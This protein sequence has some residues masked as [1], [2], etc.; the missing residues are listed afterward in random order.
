VNG[1]I[2]T[3]QPR[4]LYPILGTGSFL[5]FVHSV[6]NLMPASLFC[7]IIEGAL[8]GLFG[9]KLKKFG[10]VNRRQL[11]YRHLFEDASITNIVHWFQIIESGEFAMFD[12]NSHNYSPTLPTKLSARTVTKYPTKHISTKIHLVYGEADSISDI[13]YL[14]S[15]LPL[16]TTMTMIKEYEHM[17]FLWADCANSSCWTP[18][19][20]ILLEKD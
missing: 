8:R 10:P 19:I 3:F 2:K 14:T 11:L 6:K 16:H 9:W 1:L 5:P 13:K 15:H 18:I 17:D 4:I 7:K 20:N 12:S